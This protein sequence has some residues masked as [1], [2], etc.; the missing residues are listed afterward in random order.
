VVAALGRSSPLKIAQQLEHILLT[1]SASTNTGKP[2]K[3]LWQTDDQDSPTAA[4]AGQNVDLQSGKVRGQRLDSSGFVRT[5][6]SPCLLSDSRQILKSSEQTRG[7][8]VGGI[9][10]QAGA[11]ERRSD[12]LI[13]EDE[14]PRKLIA[15]HVGVGGEDKIK[16]YY[17]ARFQLMQQLHCKAIAKDW[18]KAIEPKKQAKY[19]YNGGKAARESG[20]DGAHDQS[21]SERHKPPWWPPEGCPHREPDHIKKD[22][23]SHSF[24]LLIRQKARYAS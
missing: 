6:L 5:S 17:L 16:K 24:S 7:D 10:A 15:F 1:T 19:P 14:K 2:A 3:Q 4:S 12:D 8:E 13:A 22:G 21:Y 23:Q 9:G 18:I 20:E 11:M